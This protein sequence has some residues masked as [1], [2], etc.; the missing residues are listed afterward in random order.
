MWQQRPQQPWIGEGGISGDSSS[1]RKFLSSRSAI[2][3]TAGEQEEELII[4]QYKWKIED[5]KL[6]AGRLA[7]FESN[8]GWR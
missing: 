1:Q 5:L 7:L 2:A 4:M 8:G 6:E 3:A